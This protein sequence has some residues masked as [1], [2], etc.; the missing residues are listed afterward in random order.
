MSKL[1][2][3]V[4]VGIR[5]AWDNQDAP[6]QKAIKNMKEVIGVGVFVN[7]E[8]P[9]LLAELD[10]FYPDKG[11]LVPSVAAA[12]EACCTALTTLA[13]D[14]ANAEWADTLLEQTESHVRFFLE[15]RVNALPLRPHAT[16][17]TYHEQVSKSRDMGMTWSNQRRGL[18]ISL[19]KSVAPSKSY[20]LSFFTGNLLKIFDVKPKHATSSN[21]EPASV[22]DWADVTVDN[23]TGNAAVIE[24]PQRHAI[25]QQPPVFDMIPDIE[26]IPRPDE[27]LLK[28][29]YHLIVRDFNS[30][31]T[32]VQCS[33]SPTLQ[34]LSDYLK[35]W[36]RTNHNNTNRPPLA[37]VKLHQSAFGLGVVYDR[38]TVATES[39]YTAQE[40]SPTM[41][42]SLIEG[43]MGYKMISNDGPFWT[44]RRDVE[45]K[46]SR[47]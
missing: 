7:P 44:F 14:E 29:P 24:I 35:K 4:Q 36:A 28:P 10:S 31:S 18:I 20:M 13:D 32:E 6:V 26:T 42:L 45:F 38:L 37:E 11:I 33:H 27:L 17:L 8:W 46:S 21:N 43:V 47:Y 3:K 19:P 41:L 34:F 15:V 2:I 16:K 25:A 39:R 22:D 23:K 40:V 12:V 9:L 5:D 30:S 1:P